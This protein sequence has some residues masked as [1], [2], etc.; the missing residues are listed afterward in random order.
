MAEHTPLWESMIRVPGKIIETLH[1][2]LRIVTMSSVSVL[3]RETVNTLQI[4][5]SSNCFQQ[6]EEGLLALS[7]DGVVDVGCVKS[8][9]RVVG[10]E[11]ASPNNRYM[12]E[13]CSNLAATCHGTDRLRSGHD[14]NR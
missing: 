7:A 13:L 14:R 3:V 5:I 9:S 11:V 10:C 6:V 4:A 8:R 12:R 1:G 2:A